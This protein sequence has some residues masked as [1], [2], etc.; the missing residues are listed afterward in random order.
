MT[1]QRE[2]FPVASTENN[3]VMF[4]ESVRTRVSAENA[5]HVEGEQTRT[6]PAVGADHSAPDNGTD[7]YVRVGILGV[8][9]KTDSLPRWFEKLYYSY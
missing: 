1:T 8:P 5:T 9:H 2:D 6:D 4:Y 7:L 3:A